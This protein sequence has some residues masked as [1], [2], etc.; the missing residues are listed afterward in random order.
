M[1]VDEVLT[2]GR[3]SIQERV[4]SETQKLL[5]RYG[6]GIQITSASIMAVVLDETVAD[7]FQKLTNAMAQREKKINEARAYANNL[8]PKA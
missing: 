4:K 2:T 7:A 6:S 8:L 5:D 1:P 3:L